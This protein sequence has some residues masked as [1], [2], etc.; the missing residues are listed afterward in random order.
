MCGSPPS[1]ASRPPR[2]PPA[3]HR[4]NP[5]QVRECAHDGTDCSTSQIIE[6]CIVEQDADGEDLS[7]APT[8]GSGLV[9]MNM[10]LDFS[11]ARLEIREE[12]NEMV[13]YQE[14]QFDLQWQDDRLGDSPCALV[15]SDLISMDNEEA[16]SDIGR[17]ARTDY[18][19]RFW[20]PYPEADNLAPGFV[21]FVDEGTFVYEDS[22][23]WLEGLAPENGSSPTASVE[24]SERRREMSAR[25]VRRRALDEERRLATLLGGRRSGVGD[26]DGERSSVSES[27]RRADGYRRLRAKRLAAR[28][29]SGLKGAAR[30]RSSG[31][32]P[33]R[34]TKRKEA[35]GAWRGVESRR[36]SE[37]D[38][39][40]EVACERCVTWSGSIEYDVLTGFTYR[41]FP[42]DRQTIELRLTVAD[43]DLYTCTER[44]A[45]LAMGLTDHN[46]QEKLLPSSGQWRVDGS[47]AS[48][49]TLH[50]PLDSDSG[51]VDRSSCVVQLRLRR[52]WFVFFFKQICTV[53]LVTS[54]GLLAL[55]MNPDELLGDRCAQLLVA[56]LIL[57]TTLQ[58]DLG[59]GQLSYLI[60]VDYFNLMQLMVL[61]VALSQTM[62]IHRLA[63]RK[64]NDLVIII[65]R[66]FRYLLPLSVYP[67]LVVGMILTGTR[68]RAPGIA[69]IVCGFV[70]TI[71]V[72]AWW[73]K[74]DYLRAVD[75]RTAALRAAAAIDHDGDKYPSVVM[76][77]FN[78]FDIDNSGS[79]DIAEMR[80]LLERQ[81]K[82][83]PRGAL[84]LAMREVRKFANAQDDLD[85]RSFAD[86]YEAAVLVIQGYVSPA[87]SPSSL[88]R[89]PSSGLFG[90]CGNLVSSS[91]LTRP[92]ASRPWAELAPAPAQP[93]A[94]RP[95][96]EPAPAAA[97]SEPPHSQGAELVAQGAAAPN[98]VA[99]A[100]QG[101]LARPH[102]ERR[103]HASSRKFASAASTPADF[104]GERRTAAAQE[105]SS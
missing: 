83:R 16:N 76:E 58:M 34:R 37:V 50:H 70:M 87:P 48:A 25:R 101:E 52:D 99:V 5:P 96:A 105:T 68:H 97:A 63:C 9:P 28:R 74:R 4:R 71:A 55:L 3:I 77:L 60:W 41:D 30:G 98:E 94:Y 33:G 47:L 43:A 27:A 85:P 21:A 64:H 18:W 15:L 72:G 89:G 44:D 13:L 32:N 93:T 65:D 22:G 2:P 31:S 19:E 42:F 38:E 75:R 102:H 49:L 61:L 53:L 20:V 92:T 39:V 35:R 54:G 88:D 8:D 78:A 12:I 80:A 56:V 104:R 73:V 23:F 90:S 100:V 10:Q 66:V 81:F 11:A 40:E 36:L 69:T 84:A 51:E 7:S 45:F 57:V 91:Q 46:V 86:A 79:M 26:D 17:N 59:L 62:V 1:P 29:G 82:D 103:R 6:K 14:I 67:S 95:W 24:A